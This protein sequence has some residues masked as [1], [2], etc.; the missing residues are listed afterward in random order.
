[1]VIINQLQHEIIENSIFLLAMWHNVSVPIRH[2]VNIVDILLPGVAGLEASSHAADKLVNF[3]MRLWD[4]R[5]EYISILCVVLAEQTTLVAMCLSL[6]YLWQAWLLPESR[7]V[8]LNKNTIL[9]N[10]P[11]TPS[12]VSCRLPAPVAARH[13]DGLI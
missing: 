13:S 6:N 3:I 12:P 7:D 10:K 1:M 9:Q 8:P 11:C 5:S 4:N 2:V